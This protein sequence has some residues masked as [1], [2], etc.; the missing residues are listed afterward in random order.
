[1]IESG[2]FNQEG[3]PD[4]KAILALIETKEQSILVLKRRIE[5]AEFDNEPLAQSLQ[6]QVVELGKQIEDLKDKLEGE[7]LNSDIAA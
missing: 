4:V 7:G 2:P 6:A 5:K 3:V 1:M